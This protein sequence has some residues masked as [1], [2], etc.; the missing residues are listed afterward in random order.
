[1]SEEKKNEILGREGELEESEME[2]V[3]GGY[4][5]C[6]CVFGGYGDENPKPHCPA[7][8]EGIYKK[9]CV[10]VRTGDGD[11]WKPPEF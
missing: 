10:C 7:P 3:T 9:P 6:I 1:M 8:G 2:A 11:D 5:H 4:H